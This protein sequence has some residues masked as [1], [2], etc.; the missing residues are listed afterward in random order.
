MTATVTEIERNTIHGIE[1]VIDRVDFNG[2]HNWRVTAEGGQLI[3]RKVMGSID[4]ARRVAREEA[5]RLFEINGPIRRLGERVR[6]VSEH[7]GD[8]SGIVNGYTIARG[9]EIYSYRVT[10]DRDDDRSVWDGVG[11]R[12][13]MR[14]V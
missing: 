2:I 10:R 14:F 7:T 9:G 6:Y 13:L 5:T 11:G 12:A 3:F 4:D 1:T 8:H